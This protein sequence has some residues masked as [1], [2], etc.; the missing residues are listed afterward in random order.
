[1]SWHFLLA[2]FSEQNLCFCWTC[3][4]KLQIRCWSSLLVNILG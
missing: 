4:T 3:T 1:M 2:N